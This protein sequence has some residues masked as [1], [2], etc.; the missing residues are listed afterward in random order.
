MKKLAILGS[1]G[2]IGT[3][4][5][6]VLS[7]LDIKVVSLTTNRNIDL[8][9]RQARKLKPSIVGVYDS[10]AAE[11]LKTR[12]SG[13][14][15]RIVSG[16]QGLIE[17][18]SCADANMVLTAVVGMVGLLP[19]LSAIENGIDIALANKETLVCAGELVM[20][21]AKEKNVK[22][23]PVDSEH[24]AIF[25]CMQGYEDDVKR[26]ILTASGGPFFGK[27]Q[28]ELVTVKKEDALK[29]PNWSMGNKITIDSATMMNKGFEFLEAMWLYSVPPEMIEVVVHRESII[30]SLVEF[31]DNSML[32]QMACPDMRLPIQYALTYPE[33]K[34]SPVCTLDLLKVR[35]LSFYEPDLENFPCLKMAMEC[36]RK[37]GNS[38]AVLNA[39]N[40][41]AVSLFLNDEIGFM[42]IPAFIQQAL[43]KIDFVDNPTLEEILESDF[44]AR[45]LIHSLV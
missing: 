32:A 39:A 36:A 12:L 7:G 10:E 28:S 27:N 2:S 9:E 8:M 34:R 24:S 4:A 26:I 3:Q 43:D 23:L 16:M 1:T 21:R 22:I 37:K 13:L 31:C 6:D 17:A 41:V 5:V 18:A 45:T 40:E 19:T 29:H 42:E 25:Q 15:I 11:K 33:R 20:K 38:A 44:E 30:H 35:N 14:D